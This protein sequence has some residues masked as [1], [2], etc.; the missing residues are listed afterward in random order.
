[1][2][3]KKI[4]TFGYYWQ[5]G[6]GI[7][8]VSYHTIWYV[9]FGS[10][11]K[12]DTFFTIAEITEQEYFDLQKKYEEFLYGDVEGT[13]SKQIRSDIV[14]E[15]EKYVHDSKIIAEGWNLI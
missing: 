3:D 2:C 9:Y 15:I 8:T 5:T 13:P 1:M 6:I 12:N 7:G 14:K 4:K 10:P 11:N